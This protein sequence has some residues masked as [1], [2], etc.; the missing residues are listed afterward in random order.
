MALVGLVEVAIRPD[1]GIL[2]N[3][4]PLIGMALIWLILIVVLPYWGA[5]RQLKRQPYLAGEGRYQFTPESIAARFP[6]ITSDLQ[7]SAVQRIR[8]TK[9]LFLIYYGPSIAILVPRRFF[10]GEAQLRDWMEIVPPAL[11]PKGGWTP[12]FFGRWF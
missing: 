6:R 12:S 4:L 8:V 5:R 11:M 2:R 10:V 7:W 1:S 9:S 3:L